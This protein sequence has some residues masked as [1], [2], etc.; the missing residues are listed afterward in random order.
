MSTGLLWG[1]SVQF[2]EGNDRGNR[3][4][5]FR[6]YA[7]STAVATAWPLPRLEDSYSVSDALEE[8]DMRYFLPEKC[9]C[10]PTIESV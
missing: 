2:G 1:D 6:K 5:A 4:S 8:D 7:S 10:V 9:R 3:K